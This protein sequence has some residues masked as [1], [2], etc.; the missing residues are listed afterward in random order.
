VV[1]A[2]AGCYYGRQRAN[3]QAKQQRQP[4]N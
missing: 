4:Q 2:A 1:G 3:Q